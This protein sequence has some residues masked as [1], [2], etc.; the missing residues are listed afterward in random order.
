MQH[1]CALPVN[2][3]SWRKQWILKF[4]LFSLTAEFWKVTGKWVSLCRHRRLYLGTCRLRAA[5]YVAGE[6]STR[7]SAAA[8]RH[9]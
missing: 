6:A 7:R 2:M 9:G 3:L 8:D 5:L 4:L 1:K